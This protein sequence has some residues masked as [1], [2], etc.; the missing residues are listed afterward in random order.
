MAYDLYKYFVMDPCMPLCL[1]GNRQGIQS[2]LETVRPLYGLLAYTSSGSLIAYPHLHGFHLN[3][4]YIPVYQVLGHMGQI[5]CGLC[6]VSL[7]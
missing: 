2:D 5:F 7:F 3:P 6:I 4:L 1:G